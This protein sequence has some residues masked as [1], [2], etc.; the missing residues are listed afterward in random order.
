MKPRVMVVTLLAAFVSM[1][2]V[3]ASASGA[4][5]DVFYAEDFEAYAVGEHPGAWSEIQGVA[6]DVVTDEWAAGGVRSFLSVSPGDAPVK[7]DFVD[8]AG[9]GAWPLPDAFCYEAAVHVDA[10]VESTAVVGFFFVDPRYPGQVACENAVAFRADGEIMWYGPVSESVGTWTPG[11]AQTFLVRVEMDFLRLSASVSIDGAPAVT[12]LDA[13]GKTI[14]ATS[15]YGAE[16]PLDKWGFG[17]AHSFDGDGVGRVFIDDVSLS[18]CERAPCIEAGVRV[19]PRTLN[20][21]SRGRYVTAYIE[22]P[23]G[24]DAHNI[25][26]STVNLVSPSG[27][28]IYA[29]PRPTSVR[30][31][32]CDGL[33]ELMVKFRRSEL[34]DIVEPAQAVIL[35]ISGDLFDGTC[36]EG[37]DQ[38]R[39][40]RPGKKKN[41]NKHGR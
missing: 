33:Y 34:Q 8:L 20:L 4:P 12:G 21:K 37:S 36:F 38:I 19:R 35:T 40:I 9:V 3:V 18:E 7:R 6:D 41:K 23:Q 1:F 22:L 32:D 2:F 30:D 15:V 11:T 5:G 14:P 16:A 31:R 24:Y 26:V 10:E 13:W 17:L 25:D 28:P 29:L 27:G 39:V